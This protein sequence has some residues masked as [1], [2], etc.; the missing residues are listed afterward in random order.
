VTVSRWLA[1]KGKVGCGKVK[2]LGGQIVKES[3]GGGEFLLTVDYRI[4]V[5]MDLQ[6]D[7]SPIVVKG[8]FFP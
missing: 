6:A 5:H 3:S 4:K 1:K 7:K 2:S 8:P